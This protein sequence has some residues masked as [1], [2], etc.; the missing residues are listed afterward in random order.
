[1]LLLIIGYLWL[2]CVCC[3]LHVCNH[4]PRDCRWKYVLINVRCLCQINQIRSRFRGVSY[5]CLCIKIV[6]SYGVM[7]CHICFDHFL[8]W[9]Q[10]PKP[11]PYA[12]ITVP[13]FFTSVIFL[14]CT[15]DGKKI[16]NQLT[17]SVAIVL[18]LLS[19]V[20]VF[21]AIEEICSIIKA[22]Q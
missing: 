16:N 15:P 5:T 12:Y 9:S 22:C 6:C 8:H 1:M 11:F 3:L 4:F 19:Y 7:S 17:K 14:M 21:D 10:E 2:F 13:F 18:T 20:S